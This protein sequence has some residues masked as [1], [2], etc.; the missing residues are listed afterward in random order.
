MQTELE[1]VIKFYKQ[2]MLEIEASTES[3]HLIHHSTKKSEKAAKFDWQRY[4][5]IHRCAED[6]HY[7][8]YGK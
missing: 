6:L 5:H 1:V 3:G 4:N 2:K 7:E 8:L